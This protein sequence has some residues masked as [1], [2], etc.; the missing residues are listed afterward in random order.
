MPK[1]FYEQ[2]RDLAALG[3]LERIGDELERARD[4]K[5]FEGRKNR[6]GFFIA[7]CFSIMPQIVFS[8]WAAWAW[9]GR[10]SA[11]D[12]GFEQ[13]QGPMM[14]A[15]LLLFVVLFPLI[16]LLGSV[17]SKMM[18]GYAQDG[19][20]RNYWVGLLFFLMGWI[21]YGTVRGVMG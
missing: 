9:F 16:Y 2:M 20:W 10:K 18:Q 8:F 1:P 7:C 12:E 21:I 15:S 14:L 11:G 5:G 13:L 3:Q 17:T 6:E 4:S 19:F